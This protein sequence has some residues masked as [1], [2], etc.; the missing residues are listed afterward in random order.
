M[1]KPKTKNDHRARR[2]LRIRA[3]LAGTAEC[4]RLVVFR[5]LRFTYAQLVDDVTHKVLA[6][7]SDQAESKASGQSKKTK[8]ERAS[9]IGRTIGEKALA[10]GLKTCVFD[11]NGYKYHGRVKAVADGAR[12][13][14]LV[15]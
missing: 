8:V 14:G 3:R 9:E 6:S 12:E 5:S 2:H 11:R 7:V 4:P 13:S 15:F 10:E 1:N